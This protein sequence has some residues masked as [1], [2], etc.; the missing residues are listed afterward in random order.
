MRLAQKVC[1]QNAIIKTVAL[2]L[3]LFVYH[4]LPQ[5]L[6]TC[7]C[8]QHSPALAGRIGPGVGPPGAPGQWRRQTGGHSAI[9]VATR[10]TGPLPDVGCVSVCTIACAFICICVCVCARMHE[11]HGHTYPSDLLSSLARPLN[12]QP[13]DPKVS[14]REITTFKNSASD[15]LFFSLAGCFSV[16]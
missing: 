7:L 3:R 9:N 2:V 5:V 14:L 15:N 12:S 10:S 8:A 4:F 13:P 6:I 11:Q 16:N 1:S